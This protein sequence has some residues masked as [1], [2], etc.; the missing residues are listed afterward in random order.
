MVE[1]WRY[2]PLSLSQFPLGQGPFHVRGLAYT[3][4][5][6]YADKKLGR[7]RA[8]EALGADPYAPFFA[9]I[10]VLGST[11]DISPLLRLYQVL[12]RLEK[13][14]IGRFVEERARWSA[15]ALTQQLWRHLFRA[16]SPEGMAEKLHLAFNRYFHPCSAKTTVAR[17]R[18]DGE[19]TKIPGPMAGLYVSSTVGFI[20]GALEKVGARSVKLEFETPKYEGQLLGI[21]LERLRFNATW[22]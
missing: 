20:G 4:S 6:A 21:T 16:G 2:E 3:T 18:V 13:I 22:R 19:L 14:S 7:G 5:L 11:Y 1:V 15:G 12:A 9:Q 8:I 17:G 10:F